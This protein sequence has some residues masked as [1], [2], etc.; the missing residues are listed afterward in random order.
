[1]M[2]NLCQKCNKSFYSKQ[3]RDRHAKRYHKS[4]DAAVSLHMGCGSTSNHIIS[5]GSR[6][7]SDDI[8]NRSAETD[9]SVEDY[10]ADDEENGHKVEESELETDDAEEIEDEDT[11]SS[12]EDYEADHEDNGHEVE[13]SELE[14]DDAEETEDQDSNR[15]EVMESDVENDGTEGTDDDMDGTDE[16]SNEIVSKIEEVIACAIQKKRDIDIEAWNLCQQLIEEKYSAF[17]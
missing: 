1:M 9:S 3:S 17:K 6:L 8:I 7:R 12:V 13:E 4:D 16:E 10:E 5:S 2:D 11:D 14:T 15:Y